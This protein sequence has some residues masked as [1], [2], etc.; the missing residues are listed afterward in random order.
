MLVQVDV[1]FEQPVVPP[2][3]I[4][5]RC[6][7]QRSVGGLS[8]FNVTASVGNIVV[9]RGTIALN[10]SPIVAASVGGAKGA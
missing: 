8:L 10:C 3:E 6:Q 9:S 4:T 1:R 7:H 5:I 2:A